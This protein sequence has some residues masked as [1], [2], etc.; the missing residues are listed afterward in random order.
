MEILSYPKSNAKNALQP[1]LTLPLVMFFAL[2]NPIARTIIGEIMELI[3][4]NH[5]ILRIILSKLTIPDVWQQN[6]IAE[7]ETAF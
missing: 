4:A 2:V 6:R 7:M 5:A 3:T 1:H